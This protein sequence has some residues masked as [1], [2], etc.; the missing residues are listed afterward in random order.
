MGNAERWIVTSKAGN[1]VKVGEMFEYEGK[2][3]RLI[4]Y[5]PPRHS[6]SSGHVTAKFVHDEKSERRAYASGW[7]LSI[8]LRDPEGEKRAWDAHR[9]TVRCVAFALGEGLFGTGTNM[10]SAL[11]KLRER[12]TGKKN[13]FVFAL[14][15]GATYTGVNEFGSVMFDFAEGVN[16]R[17]MSQGTWF[18]L[19]GE[20]VD[21]NTVKLK[22]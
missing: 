18:D 14:P 20:I 22:K 1:E 3:C 17:E 6:A 8:D 5:E 19:N 11:A 16:A 12:Y 15:D 2:Q 21:M 9:V 13:V 4:G 10:L 7:G